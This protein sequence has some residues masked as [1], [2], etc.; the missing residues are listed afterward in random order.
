[1]TVEEITIV[2]E[3]AWLGTTIRGLIGKDAEAINGY[4]SY[5]AGAKKRLKYNNGNEDDL[6]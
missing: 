2:I 4:Q 1:M 3:A 5:W 6:K